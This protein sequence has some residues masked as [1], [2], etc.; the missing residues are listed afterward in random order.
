VNAK[1]LN[2]KGTSTVEMA[3]VLPL[4]L[5]LIFGII[6][7]GL[8]LYDKAMITNASRE[9]ARAGIVFRATS[10]GT[11]NPLTAS[12]ITGVINNYLGSNLVSFGAGNL[13]VTAASCAPGGSITVT[14]NY[15]YHFL[16]LPNIAEAIAGPINLTA[17]TTM[18]CE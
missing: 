9:G 15:T 12:E 6:E 4:L 3:M 13:D 10:D 16:V 1:Y 11:Y 14:V 8:L 7:F 5:L 17:A 2:H 18:R